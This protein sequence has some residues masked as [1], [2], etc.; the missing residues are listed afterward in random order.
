ML[1]LLVTWVAL[2]ALVIFA[3]GRSGRAGALTLAYFLGLSLM[4]VPG[5]LPF[6]DPESGLADV[7]ETQL[8]FQMTI[9]GMAAF[10]TGAVLARWI[11]RR[12]AV[13]RGA[14]PHRRAK[15]LEGLGRR[16]CVLGIIAYFLLLPLSARVPSTTS[17]V[18]AFATLLI[19]GLWLVLYGAAVAANQRRMLATLALLPLLPVATLVT[20]G[21]LG[22]GVHWVLST[23]AFLFVI[24]RRRIWFYVAAP[25]VVFLGLSLFVTYMGQRTAIREFLQEQ[26]GLLNRLD[27]ASSI[28]TD[29]QFL[30]LSLPDHVAALDGRLNQNWLVGAAIMFHEEG[31]TPF[32]YGATIPVWALIP[33]AVWPGKPQ[34]GGG[35]SLV[36]D[37]T[38]ISVAEGTSFG[39]G[40]VME[41]YVN[42]GIPGV[43]LGFFGLGYLLM[44]LDQGIM[45]SLAA[46]DMRGFLM[47]GM[48]GLAL[49]QPQGNLLEILVACVAAYVAAHLLHSMR[50]IA[51]PKTRIATGSGGLTT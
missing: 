35:G 37:F 42:F 43:L 12:R 46:D 45:R 21:F 50:F 9:L 34:V 49:L 27:R 3:I 8:G 13:A 30:N 32:A 7:D 5:V 28:F 10:V 51:I 40:Q 4:H 6:L 14:P 18:S 11:N 19:L 1:G 33:R 47:R 20:G 23:V 2:I 17:V 41:F 36:S 39:A 15:V 38:G 31:S 16:T 48:P 26:P 25:P 24:A 22:Y 44:R 29:F